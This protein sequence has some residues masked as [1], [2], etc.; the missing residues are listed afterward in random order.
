MPQTLLSLGA[1]LVLSTFAL[2]QQRHEASL[3]QR[4]QVQEIEMAATDLA[5]SW[6]AAATEPAFDEA[7]VGRPGIRHTTTG[8]TAPDGLGTDEPAENAPGV[9][10]DVDDFHGLTRADSVRWHDGFLPFDVALS[11]RYVDPTAP[12]A[13]AGTPTLA[14]EITVLVSERATGPLQRRPVVCR[15]RA[16][17]S[18]AAQRLR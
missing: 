2:G 6:L 17:V 15:L 16:V 1:L 3:D 7:D 8:L 14:K 9:F 5:R 12:D 11:V 4:A 18:P 13:G 10:D